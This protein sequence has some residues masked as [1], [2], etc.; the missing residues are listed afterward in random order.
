VEHSAPNQD[1]ATAAV[2]DAGGAAMRYL[3]RNLAW[4]LRIDAL[5]DADRPAVVELAGALERPAPV[6]ASDGSRAA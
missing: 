6:R 5:R 2:D 3:A 4:G 1:R